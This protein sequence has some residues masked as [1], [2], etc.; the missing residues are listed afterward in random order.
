[1]LEKDPNV[2]V[3]K[4]NYKKY[5]SYVK[6]WMEYRFKALILAEAI[7]D[8]S[9]VWW[10][11]AHTRW[12][13]PK[14]LETFYGELAQCKKDPD[15][16]KE[17]SL[18][19]FINSSH[20]NFAVLN[21][22]LLDYFP[23][24]GLDTLKKNEKGLQL[25]AM[26]VYLARTPFTLEILKCH[27]NYPNR[28]SEYRKFRHTL[29]ALEEKCMNPPNSKLK[30]DVIPSWDAYAGCFRYDQSS[31]NILMFNA[32]RNHNHYFMN[33]GELSRTYNHY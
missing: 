33:V 5:P 1:M 6:N 8:H 17:S 10:I 32:F 11:D 7:R 28:L 18:M 31:L 16:D 20:S 21:T 27:D 23:T 30:C 15:C 14:P 29:C 24:Y 12:K 26:F 25:S 4:F 22:G 19:M 9:N 3:T 2:K 13:T